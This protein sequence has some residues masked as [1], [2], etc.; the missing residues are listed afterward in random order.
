MGSCCTLPLSAEAFQK[1]ADEFVEAAG[2]RGDLNAVTKLL[3]LGRNPNTPRGDGCTALDRAIHHGRDDI[4]KLLLQPRGPKRVCAHPNQ[5]SRGGW[6]PAGIAAARGSLQSLRLVMAAGGDVNQT[7]H[8]GNTALRALVQG[9]H[10]ELDEKLA[11]LLALPQLKLEEV[12]RNG[13]TAADSARL[14]GLDAVA[15]TILQ[16]V[17]VDCSL[18]P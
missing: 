6:T 5:R 12:N 7:D 11:Y 3:D 1:S 2:Y 18:S 13:E 17:S 10:G 8:H 15:A 4:V 16:K 14:K 9:E